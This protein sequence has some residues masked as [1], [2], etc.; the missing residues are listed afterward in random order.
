MKLQT[1]A[2][3]SSLLLP[4]LVAAQVSAWTSIAAKIFRRFKTFQVT[5]QPLRRRRRK[6]R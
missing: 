3:V 5:V 2:V 6:D 1:I 4:S